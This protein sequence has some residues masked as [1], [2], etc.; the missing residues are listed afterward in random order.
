MSEEHINMEIESVNTISMEEE[1]KQTL[2]KNET[3]LETWNKANK[4]DLLL[5][6]FAEKFHPE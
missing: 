4:A 3:I 6:K 5:L 2:G 1:S